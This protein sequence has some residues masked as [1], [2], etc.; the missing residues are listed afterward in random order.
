MRAVRR[1]ATVRLI[2]GERLDQSFLADLPVA[3]GMQIGLYSDATVRQTTVNLSTGASAPALAR[4]RSRAPARA[5]WQ[6]SPAR[7]TIKA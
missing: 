4:L 3:P 7:A 2:G 5:E 1:N 6:Q